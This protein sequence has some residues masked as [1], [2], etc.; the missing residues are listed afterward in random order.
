M[1]STLKKSREKSVKK[2]R[3]Y[4]ENSKNPKKLG[5]FAQIWLF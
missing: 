5:F 1:G 2:A 4:L 3:K